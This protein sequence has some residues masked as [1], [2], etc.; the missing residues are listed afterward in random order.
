MERILNYRKLEAILRVAPNLGNFDEMNQHFLSKLCTYLNLP[1]I[2]VLSVA[3]QNELLL[4]RIYLQKHTLLYD[5][6]IRTPDLRPK[7]LL[8]FLPKFYFLCARN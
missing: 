1:K 6:F 7:I 2:K 4:N 3:Y 5:N 8:E